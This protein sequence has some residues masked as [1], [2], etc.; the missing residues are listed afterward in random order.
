VNA[1]AHSAADSPPTSPTLLAKLRRRDDEA[2]WRR[3]HDTYAALLLRY[4][5]RAGLNA[6]EAEDV[7]QETLI[8]LVEKMPGFRYSPARCSFKGWLQLTV[9]RRVVDRCRR[10]FYRL[11]QAT[12][13]R[14][15]PL[16]E[17]LAATL[18]VEQSDLDRIWDEEWRTHLLEAAARQIKNTVNPRHYQIFHLHVLRRLS[19]TETARRCAVSVMTV[20]LARLRVSR[21]V[22]AALREI[23]RCGRV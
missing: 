13:P 11:A 20:Y 21:K 12:V 18:A 5:Q 15:Q 19:A 23:A 14:E 9:R 22:R 17:A 2:S 6:S 1:P 7:V 3:F 8:E 10:Q 4:A 16:D